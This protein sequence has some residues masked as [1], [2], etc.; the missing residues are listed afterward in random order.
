MDEVNPAACEK[1]PIINRVFRLPLTV[2]LFGWISLAT[3][4]ATEIIYSLLPFFL[5]RVLNAGPISLGVIEGAAE[6]TNSLLKVWAGRAADQSKKKRLLVL[7]GYCVS[8]LAR[9]FIAITTTWG[10]VLAIRMVDRA[11]KGVRG[12]PRDAMLVGWTT[13]ATRGK[14]Y[15]FHRGMDHIGA[16]VGPLLASLFLFFYPDRYRALFAL[17]AIPGA[18]A[19]ALIFLIAE[20]DEERIRQKA[21]ATQAGLKTRSVVAVAQNSHPSVAFAPL[22]QF[23]HRF[24]WVLALFTLGNS[25]DAFLLLRLTDAAG[26]V[27]FVPLMWAAL[28]VV[29][30]TTSIVGGSWSDRF[31]RREVI[32]LG[33]LVYAVVYVGFAMSATADVLF[34]WFLLYGLYFGFT[35]GAERALVA[36]FAPADR[37]GY[38][39]GIYSAVTGVGALG[40]SVLFGLI[41]SA[42]GTSAAFGLGAAIA[43][44]STVLLFA[45]IDG[46]HATH[47][48]HE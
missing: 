9:P 29:K 11:G 13:P 31:G 23:F 3:D 39:F 32:A 4:A 43:L 5:T 27:Q 45:I 25:T 48:G 12:A 21:N 10:Q 16:I 14:V 38:A 40:A 22:P 17:T 41:W 18:I 47:S 15:G 33:W 6:A 30:A 34:G 42:F 37:R 1:D 24:I 44:V 36:D 35:E 19:V 8:S 20:P 2:W 46:P 7:L 28:H 26:T